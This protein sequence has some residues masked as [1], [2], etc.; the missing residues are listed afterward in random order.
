M[1]PL[2]YI[3]EQHQGRQLENL[4]DDLKLILLNTVC[5]KHYRYKPDMVCF[6]LYNEQQRVIVDTNYF[7][8]VDWLIPGE[9]AL[10]I[11]PKLNDA[12]QVNLYIPEHAHPPFR[13][14]LTP[15]SGMLTPP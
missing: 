5:K 1:I 13:F 9:A 6:Q 11:E 12:L 8:G 10:Y 4:S 7:V 14:M 15:H 2:L 3:S